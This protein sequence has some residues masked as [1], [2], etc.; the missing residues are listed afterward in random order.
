MAVGSAHRPGSWQTAL[1]PSGVTLGALPGSSSSSSQGRQQLLKH[2]IVSSVTAA[3]LLGYLLV[4]ASWLLLA[5]IHT[6]ALNAA[7]MFW[8]LAYFAG[9]LLKLA[10][11]WKL[12]K[13]GG[14]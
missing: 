8:M 12:C 9:L 6:S 11:S 3:W 5:L 10:P 13:V 7:Y 14:G 4:P 1:E 2:C